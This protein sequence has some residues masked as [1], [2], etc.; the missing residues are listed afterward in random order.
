MSYASYFAGLAAVAT[1]NG[2]WQARLVVDAVCA[3][4]V[5]WH[6]FT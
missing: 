2:R 5:D 3:C 1:N 6:Q 4:I